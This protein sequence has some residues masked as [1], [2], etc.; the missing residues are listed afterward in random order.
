[1]FTLQRQSHYL[2][3]YLHRLGQSSN[4]PFSTSHFELLVHVIDFFL[5]KNFLFF[6]H[7]FFEKVLC[8]CRVCVCICFSCVYVVA[9]LELELKLNNRQLSFFL[10]L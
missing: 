7:F 3:Y 4:H 8:D 6:F 9:S 10:L 5:N 2:L 1:M